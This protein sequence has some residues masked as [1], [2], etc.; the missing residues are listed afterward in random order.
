LGKSRFFHEYHGAYLGVH[1]FAGAGRGIL[2]GI[3][4]PIAL[5]S[6]YIP[7]PKIAGPDLFPDSS[8]VP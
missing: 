2:G 1:N 6:R 3:P 5:H 8:S 7:F 4:W